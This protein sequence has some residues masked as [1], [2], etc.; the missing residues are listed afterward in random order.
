MR[1]KYYAAAMVAATFSFP[2]S[3]Q[4]LWQ[5]ASVGMTKAE[6]VKIYPDARPIL[7]DGQ[8][9]LVKTEPVSIFNV[10]FLVSFQFNNEKLYKVRIQAS[11]RKNNMIMKNPRKTY[12]Q[13]SDELLKRY[14]RPNK[15]QKSSFI[16]NE[17]QYFLVDGVSIKLNYMEIPSSSSSSISVEYEYLI[18]GE[19]PL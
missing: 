8:D 1:I 3:S 7:Y 15:E 13:V 16:A 17:S 4:T 6:V 11:N 5:G 18:G 12:L 2:A 9:K 19:N 10:P 14:G